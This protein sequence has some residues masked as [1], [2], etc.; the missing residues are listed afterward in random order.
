MSSRGPL[1]DT[2]DELISGPSRISTDRWERRRWW[3]GVLGVAIAFV[4]GVLLLQFAAWS[5][6][7]GAESFA[8][9]PA[10]L[11][12]PAA[13]LLGVTML[14]LLRDRWPIRTAQRQLEGWI[15]RLVR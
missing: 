13:L 14:W 3:I 2:Y 7:P 5:G 8:S 10:V 1:P 9:G 12:D 6:V 4:V 15:E 11:F